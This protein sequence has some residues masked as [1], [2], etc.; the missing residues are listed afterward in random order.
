[1]A[2]V[3]SAIDS[4]AGWPR[5]EIGLNVFNECSPVSHPAGAHFDSTTAII[6]VSV[7]VRVRA[8]LYD[9]I[10]PLSKRMHPSRSCVAVDRSETAV[11]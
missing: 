4:L 6:F 5:T 3:V 11:G 10:P 2:F 8:T 7:V 9:V 1:M